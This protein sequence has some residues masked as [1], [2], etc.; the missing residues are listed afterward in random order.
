VVSAQPAGRDC[1][2]ALREGPGSLHSPLSPRRSVCGH[3][4]ARARLPRRL[5]PALCYH[6]AMPSRGPA[7]KSSAPRKAGPRKMAAQNGGATR[8]PPAALSRPAPLPL[9]ARPGR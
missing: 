8:R 3:A 5:P 9:A 1:R 2:A 7:E 4:T 6:R